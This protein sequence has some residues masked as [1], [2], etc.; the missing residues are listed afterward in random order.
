M[1]QFFASGCQSIG[2]S[3][4]TSVLPMN[5]ENLGLTDWNSV[6]SK[7]LSRVFFNTTIWSISSLALSLLYSPTLTSGKTV[8]LIIQTFVSK[9][10]SLFYNM[11]SRFVIPF[12]PRSKCLL[13]SWL[14][15]LAT[16]ILVPKKIKPVTA[17]TFPP[18]G[19]GCHNLSFWMLSFKPA[20]ST[21]L[22]HPI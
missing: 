13:V 18:S 7:G 12:L 15:S 19:T 6:Q 14:P 20:F 17:S 4:S 11:L 22:F 16:V 2:V 5:I 3:A 10:T 9:V 8:A 21:L 1:S